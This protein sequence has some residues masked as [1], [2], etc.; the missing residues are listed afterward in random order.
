MGHTRTPELSTV[1]KIF[2][3]HLTKPVDSERLAELFDTA[4]VGK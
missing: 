1:D 4:G 3:H 2:D